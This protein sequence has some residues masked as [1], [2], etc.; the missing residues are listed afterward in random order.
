MGWFEALLAA[1]RRNCQRRSAGP[2]KRIVRHHNTV[3]TDAY[4][5]GS[6]VR[7]RRHYPSFGGYKTEVNE[8][9]GKKERLAVRNKV[10]EEEHLKRHSYGEFREEIEM[11]NH[12][13]TAQ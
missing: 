10:K 5:M 12:N 1:E 13:C 3:D 4:H 9:I 11:K 8:H 6:E 2:C 7:T